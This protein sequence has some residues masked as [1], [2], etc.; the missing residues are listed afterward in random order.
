LS[1]DA[2][3]SQGELLEELRALRAEVAALRGLGGDV[4][5]AAERPVPP[6]DGHAT[7]AQLRSALRSVH[8]T[9]QRFAAALDAVQECFAILSAV[10]DAGGRIVDFRF[11]YINPA[12]ARNNGRAV[13]D[14]FGRTVRELLPGHVARPLLER[15]TAVVGTGEPMHLTDVVHADAYGGSRETRLFDVR[16]VR[17]NDGI[18]ATWQDVTERHASEVALRRVLDTIPQ[19]VAT[20][21]ADGSI[22]HL[23]DRLLAYC[24]YTLDDL[25]GDGWQRC[26]H[27]DDL[28]AVRESWVR[29]VATGED[30]VVE[31]RVRRHDG[32]YRWFVAH[33]KPFR[34]GRGEV[35]Q[36]V[37]TLTDVHER[38]Q[39]QIYLTDSEARFR[40]MADTM[41]QIVWTARPDGF[42][43]YYNRRWYEMGGAVDAFGDASWV[44]TVHPDDIGRTLDCWRTAV[45]TGREMECQEFRLLN[46]RS[47]EYRW[48]MGRAVPVRDSGG[49]IRRWVGTTTDVHD[50]TVTQADAR[51]QR[52]RLEVALKASGTGTFRWNIRTDALTWDENLDGLFGLEPGQ[53]P[54]SLEQFVSLVH[55]DDRAEVIER[56]RR[57]ADAGSDFDMEFRVVRPDGSVRWLDDKGKTFFDP[58][59]GRPS[60]MTGACVDVTAWRATADALR[61]SEARLRQLA[62]AMPQIVWMTDARGEI[63][64]F[65]RRWEEYTGLA[66]GQSLGGAWVD[67][68]HPDD[69][70]TAVARWRR[71]VETGEPFDNEHRYRRHDGTYRWQLARGLPVRDDGGAVV[72]WLG[73]STDIHGQKLAEDAARVAGETAA[74]ALREA[75]EASRAKD[76]FLAALSHELRTPLT[77]V[78]VTAQMLEDDHSLSAEVRHDLGVIRRNVE[79]ETRLIDDLLDLTR[80]SRG[81][82][83]LNVD[84]VD[85]HAILRDAMRTC[86]DDIAAQKRL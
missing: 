55:P 34:N 73:T 13:E 75:E 24:G 38:K 53:T 31:Q 36:W 82:L 7:D 30:R 40:E 43:D 46:S 33:F 28:P 5:L 6:G 68:V 59:D 81:K 11:E 65:N 10:R 70:A 56:C 23:N 78:L 20:A 45:Q 51:E 84:R 3:K 52:E 41:P 17:L 72:R 50:L 47:G 69:R 63:D 74:R 76:E 32:A 22:E 18:V 61:E 62:D 35:T 9:E 4:S 79:L 16:I 26:V 14:H 44:P 60:Y 49:E 37:G 48:H 80:V 2:V 64:Y 83:T 21:R 67:V 77:P 15:Y 1:D 8:Q 19:F 86:S 66:V 25:K 57:C 71:A 27:P 85:V 12:G 54:R 39:A 29:A 58:A 42:V